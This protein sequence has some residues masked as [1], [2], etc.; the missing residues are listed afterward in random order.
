MGLPG[1]PPA[2]PATA[3]E[4]MSAISA[5]L[6]YL[7]GADATSLTTAE[8]A[9]CLRALEQAA[10]MHIAA[11]SRVL[12][13]FHARGGSQDDGHGSTR[14]RLK[15][16]TPI[17]RGAPGGAV[18]GGRGPAPHPAGAPAP[19]QAKSFEAGGPPLWGGRGP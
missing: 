5:G 2:V 4:A 19:G 11:R 6:S 17:P 3:G 15:W 12:S 18:R 10:A 7:N 16:E 14:T 8:Q 9:D 13:T 1:Q